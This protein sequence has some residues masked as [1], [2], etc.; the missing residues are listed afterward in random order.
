VHKLPEHGVVFIG[1]NS[2]VIED[3]QRHFG[4]IGQEQIKLAEK[5]LAD[6]SPSWV[7][8]AVMHHHVLPLESRLSEDKEGTEMDGTLV[9]DYSLVERALHSMGFDLVLHGHKHEPGIRVSRLVPDGE[10]SLIVC[11]AG[12]AGVEKDELPPSWGNHFAIYRIPELQRRVGRTFVEI[13]WR[14]LP[15][16]DINRKWTKHGPW[17]VDG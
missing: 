3:H 11:G 7:R 8:V 17:K 10:K 6:I 14:T 9:R 15:V 13:E 12:S 4:A 5:Q 16:N 1:F 2:C